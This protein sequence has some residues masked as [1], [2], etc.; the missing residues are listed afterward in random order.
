MVKTLNRRR[1]LHSALAG[2]AAAAMP[3]LALSQAY[4]PAR[5]TAHTLTDKLTLI[6]GA[7]T[8]IVALTGG[9]GV[10]LVDGGLRRHATELSDFV[11]ALGSSPRV[12]LLFN[13]NWRAEHTGLNGAVIASGGSVI[14]HEN[15]R[16]WMGNDFTVEWESL[17]HEPQPKEELPTRTFYTEEKLD[18][19]GEPVHCG[20]LAQ[21]HTDG[22]IYVF[23]PNSNVLVASDLLAVD[24]YPVVDYVTGGWIGGLERASRAL[25]D[26]CDANTLVIPAAGPPQKR[27]ALKKQLEFATAMKDTVG[28]MIKNGRSLEEVIAA[29][30][31]RAFDEGWTG[32]AELFLELAYQGLWGHIRELGGVL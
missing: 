5:L 31:T 12:E 4:G 29:E 22:D 8:N 10:A 18:F 20:Y 25:L 15:T 16:L 9:D 7:G 30:P 28:G 6:M 3:P 2:S 14:A 17:V 19:G 1:F 32:D 26:L 24:T 13:S 11:D 21:A 27:A 23:F